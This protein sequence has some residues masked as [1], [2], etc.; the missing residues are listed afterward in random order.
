MLAR[1]RAESLVYDATEIEAER[2]L[3]VWLAR[4]PGVTLVPMH[5]QFERTADGVAMLG[6]PEQMGDQLAAGSSLLLLADPYSFPTDVFLGHLN[7][8]QPGVRVFGGMA[9]GVTSEGDPRLIFG[10]R[11]LE[12]GAVGVWITRRR[13]RAKRGQPGLP[14]G[15]PSVRGD[16]GEG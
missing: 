4:L 3:V 12:D 13:Q 7:K 6:W 14:A 2:A 10:D 1:L 11:A 15:R 5:L 9:S 8:H 16:Q